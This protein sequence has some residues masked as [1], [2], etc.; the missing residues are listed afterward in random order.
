MKLPFKVCQMRSL[1]ASETVIRNLVGGLWD[2]ELAPRELWV[3]RVQLTALANT[4]MG[5]AAEM[6][7]VTKQSQHI[8]L[9]TKV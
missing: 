5:E 8:V 1:N 4:G 2:N 6:T 9:K 7:N 3:P